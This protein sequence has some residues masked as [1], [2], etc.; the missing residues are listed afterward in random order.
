MEMKLGATSQSVEV[1]AAGVQLETTSNEIGTTVN[2]SSIT[3]LP[4]SGRDTLSFALLT[5]GAQ[6]TSGYSTFNGLP[7]A[8]MNITLDGMGN[9]SERFKSGG[10]SF[11]AFAPARLD[12]IEQVTISTAGLGADA[13]GEG[14]MQIRFVT[15]S[16]HLKT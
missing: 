9:N 13:S 12:A 6:T 5:P 8:S 16:D 10:T 15:V 2:N 1:V 11:Y 4:Y 7:N 3:N 14:A